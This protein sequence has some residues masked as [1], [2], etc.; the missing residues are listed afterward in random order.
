MLNKGLYT[1][2][3]LSVSIVFEFSDHMYFYN[4]TGTMNA[5]KNDKK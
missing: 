2:Y 4:Q 3:D 5:E 1:N